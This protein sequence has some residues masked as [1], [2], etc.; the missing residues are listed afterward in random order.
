MKKNKPNIIRNFFYSFKKIIKIDKFF[1][2]ESIFSAIIS[3]VV[4][5]IVPYILKIAVDCLERNIDFYELIYKVSI[6]VVISLIFANV[7]SR[8]NIFLF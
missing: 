7:N 6:V 3:A 1:V 5:Y 8:T 2:F 4:A